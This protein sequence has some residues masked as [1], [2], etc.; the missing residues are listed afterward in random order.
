M[1]QLYKPSPQGAKRL[2]ERSAM[3][4]AKVEQEDQENQSLV[5]MWFWRTLEESGYQVAS[6][7]EPR[8]AGCEGSKD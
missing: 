4:V 6:Y 5:D 1:A 8:K 7:G 3:A 2:L